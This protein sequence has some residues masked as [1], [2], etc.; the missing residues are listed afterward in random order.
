MVA[1]NVVVVVGGPVVDDGGSVVAMVSL[2]V[3][4][5]LPESAVPPLPDSLTC[6]TFC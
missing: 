1:S 6:D 2:R 5:P 3:K 4:F